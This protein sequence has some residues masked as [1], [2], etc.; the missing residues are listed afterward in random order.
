VTNEEPLEEQAPKVTIILPAYN[1]A[2]ALPVVLEALFAVIDERYEVIVVDDASSD[3]TAE[4]AMRYPCLLLRHPR[5]RGKGAAIKTG[6]EA[7]RGGFVVIMDADNTYPVDAI[8]M[9]LALVEEQDYEF[10]RCTRV[11]D[12]TTM[13]TINKWGNKVF[14]YLLGT[15]H[16]LEGQDHLTGLYGLK[17]DILRCMDLSAERFD[18]EVEIGIKAKALKLRAVAVPVHYSERLGE[19]KLHAL[20]DGWAILGRTLVMAITQHPLFQ[21]RFGG[22]A[23]LRKS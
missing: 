17:R 14:D 2:E 11:H 13:P 5:N 22:K 9:M 6:L 3:D 21:A 20:R 18:I 23:A 12:D 8:P 7:A 15:L 1:E 16:G 10:V 4:I 19:K